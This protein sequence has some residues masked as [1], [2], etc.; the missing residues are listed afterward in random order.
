VFLRGQWISSLS[1]FDFNFKCIQQ[2]MLLAILAT[3]CSE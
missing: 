1:C 3:Y 2:W